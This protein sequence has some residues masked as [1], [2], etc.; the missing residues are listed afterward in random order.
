MLNSWHFHA[1][2]WILITFYLMS[3]IESNICAPVSMNLLNLLRKRDKM[4]GKPHILYLFP[5]SFKDA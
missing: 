3:L 5:N 2:M 1:K 4:L